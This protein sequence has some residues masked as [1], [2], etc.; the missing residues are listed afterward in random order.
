MSC[1]G[2][3]APSP[4]GPLHFGSLLAALASY[5]DMRSRNGEWLLRIE[6]LDP[7]REQPGAVDSILHTLDAFGLH[8]DG[9]VIY[10]STRLKCYQDAL[11]Q[12]LDQGTAYRCSC[13]RKQLRTRGVTGLYDGH[14]RRHPPSASASCA[15]RV[16]HPQAEQQFHDRIQGFRTYDWQ[17]DR[18]DFVVFRRDGLFAYQLAV[19][20]DDAAAGVTDIV[21]GSDLI[22]ETPH[23]IA[24]QTLLGYSTPQY[25]HIPVITN[26]AGQKLSKQ[27]L[28]PAIDPGQRQQLLLRALSLLGQKPPAD[29]ATASRDELLSWAI[30]HWNITAVPGT[31]S[32]CEPET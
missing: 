15:V 2:R 30:T 19:V 1:I 11:E 21:R 22:D 28:A 27:N 32:L 7:P 31:L 6:D 23:Q 8:W 18:G 4:T 9:P 13:S 12:L 17:N 10:Q 5:L 14:C 3:F 25:A 20:V 16:I 26:P 29:L 24:L